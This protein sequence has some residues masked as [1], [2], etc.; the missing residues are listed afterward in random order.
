ML[1]DF[2]K[3]TFKSIIIFYSK[4]TTPI[5]ENSRL[6]VIVDFGAKQ[7]QNLQD[8]VLKEKDEHT[9][10]II[11]QEESL[12]DDLKTKIKRNQVKD[13]EFE[14]AISDLYSFYYQRKRV[15]K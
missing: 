13:P 3:Y 7:V 4:T 8:K 1:A 9:T 2:R 14:Q 12:F 5:N 10:E 15:A 11:A 6:S